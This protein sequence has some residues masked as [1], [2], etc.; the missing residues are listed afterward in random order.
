ACELYAFRV[1]RLLLR[2]SNAGRSSLALAG[3]ALFSGAYTVDEAIGIVKMLTLKYSSND[4]FVK[5]FTEPADDWYNW[6]G[7]KYFLYEYQNHLAETRKRN[8][9]INW[10]HLE[11]DGSK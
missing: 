10:A 1:Y 3:N 5:V 9:A 11:A 4:D 8:M 2:R 6:T 7:L